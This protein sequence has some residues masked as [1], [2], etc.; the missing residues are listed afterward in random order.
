MGILVT[1]KFEDM[2]A[3]DVVLVGQGLD[4][5][6]HGRV[7]KLVDKLQAQITAQDAAA[8]VSAKLMPTAVTSFAHP[9]IASSVTHIEEYEDDPNGFVEWTPWISKPAEL[10]TG[11]KRIHAFKCAD[12]L[13]WN[14]VTGS[15]PSASPKIQE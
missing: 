9:T 15:Q 13:V 6:P 8:A 7:R 2:S 12:G 3:E 14:C 11:G 5:L 4:F 10:G 1:Y